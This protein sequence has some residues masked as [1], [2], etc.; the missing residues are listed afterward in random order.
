MEWVELRSVNG[1][2]SYDCSFEITIESILLVLRLSTDRNAFN[3]PLHV[4]SDAICNK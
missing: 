4:R 3:D 1:I 2:Q